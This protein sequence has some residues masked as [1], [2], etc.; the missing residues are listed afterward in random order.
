MLSARGL[1][2][3][4]EGRTEDG[5]ELLRRSTWQTSNPAGAG[6]TLAWAYDM[7][8]QGDSA[9]VAYE[10]YLELHAG[11][12]R[13]N[14]PLFLARAC[15]RLGQL[16]EERGELDE[17][18]RYHALFVD[19]WENADPELQPRVEAARRALERLTREAAGV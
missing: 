11:G 19:L 1:I 5:L 17:A 2:A 7:A 3:L 8:G 13:S 16:H 6:G 4:A 14:D 9:I 12:R 15:E 10:R 18:A